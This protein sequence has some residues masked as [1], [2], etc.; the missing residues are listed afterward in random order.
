MNVGWHIDS[1]SID[2]MFVQKLTKALWYL[3][4]HHSKFESRHIHIPDVFKKFSGYNDYKHKKEK[5]PPISADELD[6]HIQ[7]LAN[8]LLQPWMSNDMFLTLKSETENLVEAMRKYYQYLVDKNSI[9]AQ[10]R[11]QVNGIVS[12][13]RKCLNQNSSC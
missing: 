6:H 10:H 3:D 9:M 7:Q 8:L 4:P 5:A 1:V 2:E 12:D 13:I 11:S